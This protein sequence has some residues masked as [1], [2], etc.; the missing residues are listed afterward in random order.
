MHWTWI[1][2]AFTALGVFLLYS[3]WGKDGLKYYVPRDLLK[4]IHL[5]VDLNSQVEFIIFMIMGTVVDMAFAEPDTARQSIAAGIGWTGL[6][7]TPNSS[8]K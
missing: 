3:R 1:H 6:L 5:S 7:A 2:C 4:T 8:R